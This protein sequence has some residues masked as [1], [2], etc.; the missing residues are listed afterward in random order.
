MRQI[1]TI[2]IEWLRS[3]PEVPRLF[4]REIHSNN[5][6]TE[7]VIKRI[8]KNVEGSLSKFDKLLKQSKDQHLIRD[9]DVLQTIWNL[10]SMDLF[11][12]F[13][14][15]MLAII[16]NDQFTDL[17]NMNQTILETD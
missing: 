11:L 3:H 8:K 15:P 9:I 13:T 12:F 17:T 2:H 14:K 5:P 16:W 4:I 10:V 6:I 1:V 7:R